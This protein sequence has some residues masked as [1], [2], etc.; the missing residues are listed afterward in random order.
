MQNIVDNLAHLKD[1][2]FPDPKGMYSFI[3]NEMT[4]E[5]IETL[6]YIYNGGNNGHNKR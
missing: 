6:V 2:G 4:G 1:D 5:L 3:M